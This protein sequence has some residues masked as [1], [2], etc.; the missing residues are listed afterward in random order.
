MGANDIFSE[1]T[2]LISG[3]KTCK[4][5]KRPSLINVLL[6]QQSYTCGG[7][8]LHGSAYGSEVGYSPYGTRL[9]LSPVFLLF[10][11]KEQKVGCI[12]QS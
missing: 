5:P 11:V 3:Q 7:Q 9:G 1:V 4:M 10:T 6:Y 2:L 12:C 8:Y